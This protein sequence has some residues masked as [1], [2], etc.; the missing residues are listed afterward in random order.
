[1]N[2]INLPGMSENRL[3][4]L[5]S[6]GIHSPQDLINFFP[7]R[8]LDKS[9]VFLTSQLQGNGEKATI[10]GTI[11]NIREIGAGRKKRL[12]ATL[13]DQSG[14]IDGVWFKGLAYFRNT[15]KKGT[16]VSFYGIA[17]RFGQNI[18]MT[19]PDIDKI[20]VAHNDRKPDRIFPIYPGSSHFSKT[21]ITSN[22]IAKWIS[23]ILKT[24]QT[25]EFL[26]EK[27][28]KELNL[29]YQRKAYKMIHLPNSSD[30]TQ[31]AL[32]RFKFEELFLF[33]LS[34]V[35]L[36]MHVIDKS[37]G[38]RLSASNSLTKKFFN[39]VLP[40]ELTNGQI[41]ALHQIK[42]D[43][44]SGN[45]MNRLI[46]GDVGSGKTVVAIGAMLMAIDNGYQA[47][48]MAPTEI[49]GEQHYRTLSGYLKPLGLNIRLLLGNQK[50]ALR[51]D[52]LSDIAGGSANIIVG[53]HAIIQDHVKFAKLGMAVIDE[54]HRFG[55]VQRAFLRDKGNNPHILVMSATPIP[56]SLALTLYSDLDVSL[57]K[58][59]PA[60]RK[61]IITAIRGEKKRE[62]VYGFI[63]TVTSEGGQVYIVY[64]LVEESEAIDLKDATMGFEQISHR[65]PNCPTGLL[66][67]RMKTSEKDE[68]MQKFN[69]NEIQILVTTTVIEVGV[70]V[71]NA[72]VMVV[73][74]AERF[75]LSQ[76]HQ[77]RGR[78]G[79]GSNQSY[80]ILMADVKQS[81]EARIRL[82]TMADTNDGF[83]V[84][85]ADLKLRGPGDFLGTKQSGLPDFKVADIIEDQPLLE[86]AKTKALELLAID[87]ELEKSENK[88][89]KKVFI[90]ILNEKKKYFQMS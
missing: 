60:G 46:Q 83:K 29:P 67:G 58:D 21:Y 27:L 20:D 36:K 59:L 34:V 37:P 39:S 16:N 73:E 52:V 88:A 74:H 14:T 79:R 9:N 1:M 66:H 28:L 76:L 44:E 53:T 13:K 19:H 11:I 15:L 54:Q 12:V 43:V 56:R 87:P 26:P 4:A 48:F 72:S 22:I 45:Q 70:D 18:T 10:I 47:A 25:E 57:I 71:S 33:E 51:T 82:K 78:I 68:I 7:R 75:G 63:D 85:E 2:L 86:L 55:V 64:P 50:S 90:P 8:Y 3:K 30:D 38:L 62:A 40:F 31:M 23:E 84:S 89:L 35:K 32:R 81:K 65:F 69:R 42:T 61:P 24:Y 17:K 41:A 6:S 80:C 77:L 49:L 5:A